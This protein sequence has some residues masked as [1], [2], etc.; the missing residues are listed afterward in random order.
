MTENK[1]VCCGRTIPEGKQ[2]CRV[3]WWREFLNPCKD[4][5][6]NAIYIRQFY[7]DGQSWGYVTCTKCKNGQIRVRERDRAIK[8][9]NDGVFEI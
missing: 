3:C 9:W 4:C 6:G 5:G 1:C 7:R 2:V 8:N